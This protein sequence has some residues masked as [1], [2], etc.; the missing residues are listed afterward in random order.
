MPRLE[1]TLG[2]H[3]DFDPQEIAELADQRNLIERRGARS[4]F[5]QKV[6]VAVG[7]NLA[8]HN[9]PEYPDSVRLVPLRQRDD[10][11]PLAS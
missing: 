8:P 4:K 6:D 9:G 7:T 5:D 10:P 11:F 1:A 2:N 3:V